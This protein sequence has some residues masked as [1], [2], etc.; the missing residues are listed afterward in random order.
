MYS[1]REQE[2]I[3]TE[4]QGYSETAASKIEGTFENDMLASNSIEFAKME[5]E[6]EQAYKAAFAETSWGEYLTMI[7]AEFGIDRKQA[8]KATGVVTL[9]GKGT[10]NEGSMFATAAGINFVTTEEVEVDGSAQ[11]KI[12]AAATG[13]KGNVLAGAI[14]FIPMSIPGITAVTNENATEGGYDEESDEDLLERYFIAVRTPA[15]S[16]NKWHYYNWAMSVD[17]V[18]DCRV[19]PLWDGPGTV[20]VV[21][22]DSNRQTAAQELMDSVYEYIESV[23]P[24]GATVT[25][26]TPEI[27]PITVTADIEG[28]L[29]AEACKGEI[30]ARLAKKALSLTDLSYA[31]VIDIIMNQSSVEDCDNVLLNGEKR[32][33]FGLDTLPVVEE[34]VA[35]VISS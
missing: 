8:S 4:L 22:V 20:K 29:D 31:Q 12:E 6:L 33:T 15:T 3:L 19:L 13:S 27:L 11:V 34:V 14:S 23:R 30:N 9:T 32:L 26:A 18:G 10:V 24:I 35:S 2:D 25:V 5:V 7:A 16:G 17:G 1:A 21:I 28:T